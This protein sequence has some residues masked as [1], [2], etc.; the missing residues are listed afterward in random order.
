MSY[1]KS[2]GSSAIG[3]SAAAALVAFLIGGATSAATF[4]VTNAN[5]S[6]PG[7]LSD[8]V[9][10]A[11]AAAGPHTINITATGTV[12]LTL[13]LTLTQ[14][15]TINGPPATPPAFIL[16]GGNA[17]R[18]I[19]VA[20]A[21]AGPMTLNYL[22][23][24]HGRADLGK[25]GAV[26]LP[27]GKTLTLSHCLVTANTTTGSSDADVYIS[28]GG[29]VSALG[30]LNVQSST[31]S[32][33]N[34]SGPAG[35][36]YAGPTA[37]V[38]I[39][40]TLF[41]GNASS[42]WAGA[43][44]CDQT[45]LA[46]ITDSSFSYNRSGTGGSGAIGFWY[47]NAVIRGSTFR[48][49]STLGAGGAMVTGATTGAMIGIENTTM[50]AN[51]ADYAGAIYAQVGTT[52]LRNVTITGN[53]AARVY[54]GVYTPGEPVITLRNTI[55]AGN[56]ATQGSPD[57]SGVL[58]SAGYNLVGRDN[59]SCTGLVASDHIVLS[60]MLSGLADN[61]GPT[62]THAP[63]KGSQAIDGGNPAGCLGLSGQTLLADQRGQP[64]PFNGRCDIGALE[65]TT[66]PGSAK[67]RVAGH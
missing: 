12:A 54:G 31:F 55:L 42:A 56:T 20:A 33:N 13:P 45:Q 52:D 37:T 59:T 53:A 26:T 43:M 6:G 39:N 44:L 17:S 22:T 10:Q 63:F 18:L 15:M 67:R 57:C 9:T 1:R 49:N 2:V 28:A 62:M 3:L 11:N 25:G 30:T 40:A 7:S 34:A 24:Q 27:A 60:P 66:T 29:A 36:I 47:T 23:L 5:A 51:T 19:Q 35:A 41:N 64:R 32:D 4:T 14:A 8:A 61:G 65:E 58:T 48:N 50:S 46:T 38:T 21:A 16:D